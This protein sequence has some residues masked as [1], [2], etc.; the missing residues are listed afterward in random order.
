MSST[1]QKKTTP[2]SV[3]KFCLI[4]LGAALFGGVLSM[5]VTTGM[6]TLT[7]WG[8][9]LRQWAVQWLPAVQWVAFLLLAAPCCGF[10]YS[11]RQLVA[12]FWQGGGEDEALSCRAELHLAWALTLSTVNM[13]VCYGL[14]ATAAILPTRSLGSNMLFIAATIFF[15]VVFQTLTVRATQHLNPEKK[16]DPLS[17]GFNRQWLNSCDE[18]EK[19]D[20]YRCAYRSYQCTGATF[21]VLWVVAVISGMT[22]GTGVFPVVLISVGW[23]IQTGSYQLHAISLAK[24]RRPKA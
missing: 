8:E 16:G 12:S 13:I 22:F 4:I 15:T 24:K 20:I 19:L 18:A 21:M 10:Y 5:S 23:L 2:W 11:G 7:A 9:G 6:N 17:F 14:F 1:S 3:V